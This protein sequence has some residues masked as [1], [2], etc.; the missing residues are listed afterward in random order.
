M[1]S[2]YCVGSRTLR[3]L[4]VPF[5]GVEVTPNGEDRPQGAGPGKEG[6]QGAGLGLKPRWVGET[7][8]APP[9]PGVPV[10]PTG[11][12]LPCSTLLPGPGHLGGC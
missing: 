7:P 3:V 12:F 10:Q 9:P 4:E 1:L 2:E 11:T 5:V 8:A 6:P